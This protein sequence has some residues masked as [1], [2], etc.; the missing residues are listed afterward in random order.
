ICGEEMSSTQEVWWRP[1]GWSPF[2]LDPTKP[3]WPQIRSAIGQCLI[4]FGG[5]LNRA[6]AVSA[7]NGLRASNCRN[8]SAQAVHTTPRALLADISGALC[9]NEIAEERTN[10]DQ[11]LAEQFGL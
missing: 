3:R 1:G 10:A 5:P 7:W 8:G 6:K 11:G 2:A 4:I 9:C